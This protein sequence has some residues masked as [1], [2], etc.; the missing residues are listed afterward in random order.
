M[1]QRSTTA[2]TS[3]L[4]RWIRR[5]QELGAAGAKLVAPRDVVCA[6]WVRLKCEFGCDGWGQC[7]TCPPRSPTPERTR[8]VLD[9][10]RRLLLVH[11]ERGRAV[12]SLVRTLEREIFLAG[13]HKAFAWG[14]G[15]CR[16]C[17]ECNIEGPCAH[18]DRARPAMEAAGIDVFATA[19]NAGFPIRVVRTHDDERHYF[20]LVA[21]E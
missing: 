6:E 11:V 4:Q 13:H 15:P 20:G 3:G 2:E 7:H 12:T 16:L 10:Y 5:A 8:K 1:K 14:A 9:E 18:R 19:R 21:I 17:K